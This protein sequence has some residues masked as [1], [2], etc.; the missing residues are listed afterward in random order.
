MK[1]LKRATQLDPKSKQ[2]SFLLA[3]AYQQLGKHTEAK[4]E[5]ARSRVLYSQDTAESVLLEAT[6]VSQE[7]AQ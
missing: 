7:T 3:T 5:F 2:A 4:A 1:L 6:K